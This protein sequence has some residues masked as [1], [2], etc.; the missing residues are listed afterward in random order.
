MN[1]EM[2]QSNSP[3]ILSEIYSKVQE[4]ASKTV[5]VTKLFAIN[6]HNKNLRG[7][8]IIDAYHMENAYK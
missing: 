1:L 2:F 7:G 5:K 3:H 6:L 4:T 8:K